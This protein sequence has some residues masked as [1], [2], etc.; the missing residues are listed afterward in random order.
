[1]RFEHGSLRIECI[2][3]L[4]LLLLCRRIAAARSTPFRTFRQCLYLDED[5]GPWDACGP[6]S[7]HVRLRFCNAYELARLINKNSCDARALDLLREL[8][9]KAQR[10]VCR[11]RQLLDRYDCE[12]AYSVSWMCRDCAEAYK[13][14][15][16]AMYLPELLVEGEGLKPCRY[17]CRLV[18]QKCPYFHPSVKDQYAGERVFK[19]IDPDIPDLESFQ[20]AWSYGPP[21]RCYCPQHLGLEH[22][23]GEAECRHLTPAQL[24]WN[25]SRRGQ[26]RS[27]GAPGRPVLLWT[28]M[29]TL[30]AAWWT[31]TR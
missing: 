11:F 22:D 30:M 26:H 5:V 4:I 16:C 28:L 12:N 7:Q 21:N 15:V 13:Q 8:D 17:I 29:A 2:A 10:E 27:G 24:R 19:C 20:E 25:A 14:W 1:M 31:M 9:N 6:Q 23:S 18:E 3:A